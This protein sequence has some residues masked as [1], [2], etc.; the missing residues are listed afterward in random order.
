MVSFRSHYLDNP[1]LAER[2]FDTF[3]PEQSNRG[4]ALFFVHGGGWSGG[5][6]TIFHS[7]ALAYAEL[8]FD[9]ASTDYRLGISV[10]DQI[11]DVQESLKR[12]SEMLSARGKPKSI[13]L[14]G[15]SAGAHLALMA[16]LLLP[17]EER[18]IHIAAVCVQAAPFTFEPWP[19][20]FPAIET[21]M[22]KAIGTSYMN[23]P[24]LYQKASP[25]FHVSASMP[26]VF[27][28]LAENEH[29]FPPELTEQFITRART[30]GV[31]VDCKTY[32]RTEHGFFYSLDRWQQKE[33]FQDILA[34][35]EDI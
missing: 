11:R 34:F 15:S 18:N 8:G 32:P 3:E 9:C 19:D 26:P 1:I 2:I 30:N 25:L 6:R 7:I 35:I 20:I 23:N 10:F 33:A 24:E 21:S 29:M 27:A 31:R 17:E 4:I 22:A 16:A 28:M 5:S 12:F 13:V 14:I